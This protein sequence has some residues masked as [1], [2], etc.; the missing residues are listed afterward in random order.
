LIE[1]KMMNIVKANNE[2][3]EELVKMGLLLW[4][5]H[6]EKEI[7]EEFNRI[8]RSDRDI[9]FVGKE[10]HLLVAFVSASIKEE[11]IP[12]ANEYPVGYLEGLYVKEKYRKRGIAKE[13]IRKAE[14]WAKTKGCKEMGS[15]TWD[16]NKE[17]IEFHK[18][19]GF[20]EHS[21]LVHFIK[22]LT[23]K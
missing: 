21:T 11:H 9:V 14:E 4:P 8:L 12:G 19:L 1:S 23:K 3:F 5:K 17:S 2:D 6:S 13:L 22:K 10:D 15:D 7:K 18:K 20:T 16:W